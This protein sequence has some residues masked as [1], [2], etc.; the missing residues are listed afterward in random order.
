MPAFDL[1]GRQSMFSRQLRFLRFNI[2]DRNG[3]LMNIQPAL[4]RSLIL[5]VSLFTVIGAVVAF[6]LAQDPA[7]QEDPLPPGSNQLIQAEE[8]VQALKGA[9]KP[10]VLY[11]GPKTIYAQAHIPGAENSGPVARPEGMEK[12]RARAAS[13]AKDS[14]VVIYCG[15]CPW[16]H[17]PN[18]RPA[19][20]ELKKAGFTNVRVLY[21]EN[22]FGANWKDK[23]LPVATGE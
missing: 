15:C 18:I 14:P 17:C 2:A 12:L 4:S 9:R 11:V 23:G 19:Y 1:R 20:A 5:R 8:L 6:S 22:S 7:K 10:V 16:D 13:L 21:L 3:G